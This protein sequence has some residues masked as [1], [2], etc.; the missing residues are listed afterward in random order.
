MTGKELQTSANKMRCGPGRPH[1]RRP[2]AS[3]RAG[4]SAGRHDHARR[5]ARKGLT[6]ELAA[7]RAAY[8]EY[9]IMD[10]ASYSAGNDIDTSP[11]INKIV[12]ARKANMQRYGET[13]LFEEAQ[14][15]D[16]ATRN[17]VGNTQP[18]PHRWA[19][20]ALPASRPRRC[21]AGRRGRSRRDAVVRRPIHVLANH[22]RATAGHPSTGPRRPTAR[23]SLCRLG[24][25]G[26]VNDG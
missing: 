21:I 5:G 8:R 22:R 17:T 18:I 10:R 16:T 20:R 2:R 24:A 1:E 26:A 25:A 13:P 4:R 6:E 12:A 14:R 9:R 15:I 7:A 3:R 11:T 23:R 19:D